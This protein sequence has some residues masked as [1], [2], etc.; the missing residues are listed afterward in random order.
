M[1]CDDL[2]GTEAQDG[3]EI[4]IYIY[5]YVIM[6]DSRFCTAETNTAL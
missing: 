4:Y 5:I 1:F 2:E 3:G 6:T